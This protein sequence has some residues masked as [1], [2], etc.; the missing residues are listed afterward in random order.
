MFAGSCSRLTNGGI[1][2]V[3]DPT[4]DSHQIR[5]FHTNSS[6]F[7]IPNGPSTLTELLAAPAPQAPFFATGGRIS[8]FTSGGI[9]NGARPICEA[10]FG[11][12]EKHRVEASGNAGRRKEGIVAEGVEVRALS[13]PFDH[14]VESIVLVKSSSLKL[15]N[16]LEM[17][18][19]STWSERQSF[20]RFPQTAKSV[21]FFITKSNVQDS[22]PIL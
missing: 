21:Y 8:N 3:I 6:A 22:I 13:R 14:V 7:H 5:P 2:I 15:G 16:F 9:L 1:V 18:T 12:L 10:R 11:E 4:P 20:G 17:Q 19:S